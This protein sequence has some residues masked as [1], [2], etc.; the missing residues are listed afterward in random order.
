LVSVLVALNTVV[1]AVLLL[2]HSGETGTR[3]GAGLQSFKRRATS[4]RR[5]KHEHWDDPKIDVGGAADAEMAS[6]G[7]APPV[8][9]SPL[10]R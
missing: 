1:A 7:P 6:R 3:L 9:P 8:P 2:P 10:H 4:F 5:R